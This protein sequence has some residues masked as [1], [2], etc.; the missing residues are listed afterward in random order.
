MYELISSSQVYEECTIIMPISQMKKL[1]P[2]RHLKLTLYYLALQ[3]A[4]TYINFQADHP[5]WFFF[6]TRLKLLN[7]LNH[8]SIS[9]PCPVVLSMK[10]TTNTCSRI[11]NGSIV[12]RG[13]K[14]PTLLGITV[15]RASDFNLDWVLWKEHLCLSRPP[16]HP[17]ASF[18]PGT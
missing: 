4:S 10:Q 5:F 9:S 16:Q 7:D 1:S 15:C 13:E 11:V 18:L 17:R 8:A 2:R 3:Y 12:Y 6:P 14:D